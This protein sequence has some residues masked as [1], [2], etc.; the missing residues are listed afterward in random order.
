MALDD[1]Q[2][3]IVMEPSGFKARV[4]RTKHIGGRGY[5]GDI[6]IDDLACI[7]VGER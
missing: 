6:E 7:V 1:V 4:T 3:S 5:S 2:K